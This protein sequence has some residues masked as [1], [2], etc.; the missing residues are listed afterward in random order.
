MYLKDE[1][2]TLQYF[3]VNIINHLITNDVHMTKKS[4]L[5]EI[6]LTYP[7]SSNYSLQWSL[8]S[9]HCDCDWKENLV[10]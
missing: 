9:L 10:D 7:L 1:I 5:I 8:Y 6:S 4:W 3:Q 2:L